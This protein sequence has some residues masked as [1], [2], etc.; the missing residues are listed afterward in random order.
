MKIIRQPT[1][2]LKEDNEKLNIQIGS[3]LE[4]EFE[5]T[6]VPPPKFQ[7]FKDDE[8]LVDQVESVLRCE[9]FS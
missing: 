4:L 7:W 8:I 9:R 5:V 3:V 1:T 6:G 2:S